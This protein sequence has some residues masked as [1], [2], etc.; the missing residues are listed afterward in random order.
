MDV[1]KSVALM[2]YS[3][4]VLTVDED[5]EFESGNT[6]GL[7]LEVQC[8]WGTQEMAD[9]ILEQI[10]GVQYQPYTATT[11]I[12]EPSAEIGDAVQVNGIYGGLYTQDSFFG[13]TFYSDFS[14]PSDEQLDHEY[15]YV[16]PAERKITRNKAWTKTQFEITN[17]AINAEIEDRQKDGQEF[18]AQ[19][20]ETSKQISA[21]VSQTGGNNSS[22]GWSLVSNKFS[23]FSGNK[24]VFWCDSTGV[25]IDGKITARS[26]YIGDGTRGFEI[27]STSIKNTM[28]SL[29]DTAHNGVYVGTDGIA[30]GGGKFKVT[31]NGDLTAKSGTFDGTI[32]ASNI[33]WVK[34]GVTTYITSTNLGDSAVTEGKLGSGAVTEG[35]IGGGAVSGGKIKSGA[36]SRD[37]TASGV[38]TSLDNADTAI[39]SFNSLISGGMTA[40]W[41]KATN[42]QFTNMSTTGT[43]TYKNKQVKWGTINGTSCLVQS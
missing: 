9:D 15:T 40:T 6:S 34:N 13:S 19:F 20:L 39:A 22:F 11:A 33:A 14:A 16:S 28:T 30:L 12:V 10:K 7:T 17:G 31:S 4:V 37:K 41:L 43:V 21:K 8:P 3:R 42:A 36:V 38:K 35:K 5:L 1:T 29:N 26:G 24:E 25:T 2:P 18:R 23:L 27:G 32:Y